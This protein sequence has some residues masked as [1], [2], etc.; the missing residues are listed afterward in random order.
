MKLSILIPLIKKHD[1]FFTVLRTQL[2]SQILPYAGDI[3]VLVDDSEY[4][5]IGEKRNRLLERATG[6]YLCFFD[7]DDKPS[8]T[9]IESIMKGIE[10]NV[11]CCSLKGVI[12]WDGENPEY[13]E[14]SIM[15]NEYKT[16]PASFD[17]GEIRYERFPNHLNV[18]KASIAKQFSFPEKNF[19][20]DTEWAVKIHKSGLLEI[21]HYI[22]EV[23]YY[24]L[25]VKK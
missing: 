20:E 15:Y 2:A 8:P 4:D 23:I 12:T 11:D 17:K 25:Y 16:V 22:P 5:T 13:F 18:I 14:H 19:S 1:R 21:E 9:Y 7:S 3:E 6:E 24:Y 10:Y